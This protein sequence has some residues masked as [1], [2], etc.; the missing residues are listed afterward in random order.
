MFD[1]DIDFPSAEELIERYGFGDH[2]RVQTEIDSCVLRFCDPYLP[3]DTG[4][5][6][7]SGFTD[8]DI[9]S[10]EVRWAPYGGGGVVSGPSYA[11]YLYY[12]EVYGPNIPIEFD[13][14][15][16]PT[17]WRSPAGKAKHATG[18]DLS[19]STEHNYLAGPM[20]FERMKADRLEDIIRE[21][22]RVAL[23]V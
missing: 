13:E 12:G 7:N 3:W 11:H 5:L 8:S 23:D 22:Q 19:Y 4:A 1:V 16:N 2:G 17:A 9:G 14:L 10:G 20:W 6:R 18:R 15:G 21:A